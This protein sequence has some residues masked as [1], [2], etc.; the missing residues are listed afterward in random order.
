MR[1]QLDGKR[2]VPIVK[3]YAIL[4]L[5]SDRAEIALLVRVASVSPAESL[6]LLVHFLDRPVEGAVERALIA[7]VEVRV[8]EKM[9]LR[10]ARL[11]W[12]ADRPAP[13]R[14]TCNQLFSQASYFCRVW[15]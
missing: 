6:H 9:Q 5:L 14:A 10:R 8:L 4:Q 1:D 15:I 12:V 7:E 13:A 11:V 3:L 2:R